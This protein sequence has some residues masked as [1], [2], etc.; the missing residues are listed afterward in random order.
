[1]GENKLKV[2]GGRVVSNTSNRLD[3]SK[4]PNPSEVG[5]KKNKEGQDTGNAPNPKSS[6]KSKIKHHGGTTGGS[7]QNGG[8]GGRGHR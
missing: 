5:N 2:Y 8:R 4:W 1:M 3:P 6:D 7:S